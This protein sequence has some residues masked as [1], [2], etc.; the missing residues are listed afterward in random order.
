MEKALLW[1]VIT[2]GTTMR[3]RDNLFIDRL[4]VVSRGIFLL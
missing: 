4:L 1:I 2:V 3:N